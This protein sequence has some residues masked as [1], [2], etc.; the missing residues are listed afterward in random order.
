MIDN[1]QAQYAFTGSLKVIDIA[2]E[3][4]FTGES[5]RSVC[6]QAEQVLP[7]CRPGLYRRM[8]RRMDPPE[9]TFET[10]TRDALQAVQ[11]QS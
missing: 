8:A 5:W 6:A 7:G 10:L 11:V 3:V 9:V 2:L 4:A 1:L